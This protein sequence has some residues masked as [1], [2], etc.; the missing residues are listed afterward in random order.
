MYHCGSVMLL[1]YDGRFLS[2]FFI[3]SCYAMTGTFCQLYLFWLVNKMCAQA[4]G[5]VS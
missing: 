3:V 4:T 1:H 5:L 2:T